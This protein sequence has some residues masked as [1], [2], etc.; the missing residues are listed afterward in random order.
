MNSVVFQNGNSMAVRLIGEC[1]LPKGTCVREYREGDR[2]II[3]PIATEWPNSFLATLGSWDEEIARPSGDVR[4]PF[5][6]L[7][8]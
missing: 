1:R 2:I 7:A 5:E 3:E 4:D 8:E 6:E